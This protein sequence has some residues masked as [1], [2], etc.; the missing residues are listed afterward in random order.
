MGVPDFVH[1]M[2]VPDFVPDFGN[3]MGVPDFAVI[4][5]PTI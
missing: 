4:W 5:T 3:L 1:L 2:G